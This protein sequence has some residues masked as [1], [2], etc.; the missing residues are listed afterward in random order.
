MVGVWEAQGRGAQRVLDRVGRELRAAPLTL[1]GGQEVR[2]TFSAGVAEW[3]PGDDVR[4][5]FRRADEALYRA[6]EGGRNA[7]VHAD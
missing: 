6:K 3:R 1:V 7:V 2:L 5:L 4:G